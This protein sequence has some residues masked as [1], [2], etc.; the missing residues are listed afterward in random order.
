[1]AVFYG[2]TNAIFG[3]QSSV[4]GSAFD[5][6]FGPPTGSSWSYT[7]PDT[8]FVVE[9]NDGASF[10]N[11]DATNEII[12]PDEQVGG[13]WQQFTNIGGVDRALI[14]DYTF[15]VTDGLNTWTVGVIDVDL[16]GNNES[17]FT[18]GEDG[19]FLIFPDGMPPAG[20][21]LTVN[22]IV[23]NS[24][25]I[26]HA[27]LG[28]SVVCFAAGTLIETPRG[29]RPVETLCAGERVITRDGGAQPV[30]W[31]G[32]TT[33]PATGEAAPIVITAGALGNTETLVVS[34]QHCILLDD[35]RA[36]VYFGA[37]AVMVRARDLTGLDGIYRRPSPT[38]ITY[39]HVLLARHHLLS[40]GGIWSES[41]YP[42]D[43]ALQ[44]INPQARAEIARLVPDLGRYGPKAATALRSFEAS[45]LA[46]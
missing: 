7:G 28:G 12:D 46:A 31:A 23:A 30:L 2:Y 8:Y 6:N 15:E 19:Y 4:D 37:E 10:F 14:W 36:E 38:P 27:D 13:T 29:S 26:P 35:W 18:G 45:V 33:L 41:L 11:G 34:P 43:M 44:T 16:N 40:A 24:D 9:E 32:A 5:Y 25:S 17:D 3:T 42:G 22:G 20:T 1:M 21:A 39:C